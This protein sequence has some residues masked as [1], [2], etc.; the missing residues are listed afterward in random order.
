MPNAGE[1][2]NI[3]SVNV[4]SPGWLAKLGKA[5][6]TGIFTTLQIT[7]LSEIKF[8]HE[9]ASVLKDLVS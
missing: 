7:V 6:S 5:V 8:T 1:I 3:K 4:G 2:F 9:H